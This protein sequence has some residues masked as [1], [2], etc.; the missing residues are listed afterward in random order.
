MQGRKTFQPKL[1]YQF[2]L[3][4]RVPE[5]HLL[6]RVASGVDFSF[7]RRLTARFYSH[8][9]QPGIDPV[10]LLGMALLGWLYGIPSERRLADEVRLNLAFLWFVG[11]DLD[12]RPPDHSVLSKARAR[13]GVTVYQAFFSEIVRQCEQAGLVRGDQLYLDSTLIAANASLDSMGARAL[14]AQLANVDE[15]LAAVWRDNPGEPADEATP[16][17]PAPAAVDVSPPESSAGP[18]ALRPTDPANAPPGPL[19]GRLVSRTDPD[20]ALVARDKVPP[21]LYYKVHLGVDGGAARLVTAVDVTSG[22]VGDEQLLNRLIREHIG[23]TR[24]TVTEVVADTKYGTQAN[25]VALETARIRASIPP[26]PGGGIRRALGRE[27]FVY[28]PATARYRC[29]AG[30]PMRRMGRTR[31]GTPLGGIQY[32]ADPRACRA[33]PLKSDCC[34]T[35]V[36]RTITRPDDGGLSERVRAYL[37]TRQAKRSL[38]RRGCWVETANAEL[39]E[40]HGLRRAQCRGRA[41]VQMQAYGA[42]IA[43]NVKKL[44]AGSR[45]RPV[46][47]AGALH[48]GPR[49]GVRVACPSVRRHH[50]SASR[51]F[52]NRP[53]SGQ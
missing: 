5:G 16:P 45:P 10:V 21:G 48:L 32:R 18:R 15:H 44:V 52:G 7:V 19:N 14:V 12:E 3:E 49:H 30:Q 23:S 38:R 26:F 20:A 41:K 43:Y 9:G 53:C 50:R 37:A 42:A 47:A 1:F 34:G 33:C 39:K 36:A 17:A 22:E 31:T 25:Y 46:R 35:S 8:T 13:F 27:R 4:E 40:R 24:R 29:P 11:Y 2:S 51:H 6:R 28:D